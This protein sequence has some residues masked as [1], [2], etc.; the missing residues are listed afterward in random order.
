MSGVRGGRHGGACARGYG[1]AV[2]DYGGDHERGGSGGCG[3]ERATIGAGRFGRYRTI[4][5]LES[6]QCPHQTQA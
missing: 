4:T 2:G 5:F 6:S 3:A 1:A